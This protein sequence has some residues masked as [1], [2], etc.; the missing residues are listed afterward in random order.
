[1][2]NDVTELQGVNVSALEML[3]WEDT[4]ADCASVLYLMKNIKDFDT[5]EIDIVNTCDL[6]A[7]TIDSLRDKFE[8]K[9]IASDYLKYTH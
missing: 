2:N 6:V 7:H 8:R 4:L 3:G 9:L 1:M 5:A